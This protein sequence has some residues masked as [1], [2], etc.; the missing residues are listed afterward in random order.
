VVTDRSGRHALIRTS[1]P[2]GK[3]SPVADG[4]LGAK[5]GLTLSLDWEVSR[6]QCSPGIRYGDEQC[7]RNQA[8]EAHYA[9]FRSALAVALEIDRIVEERD[10]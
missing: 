7:N 6:I 9:S 2:I 8:L 4:S 10:Q 3:A 1:D 5:H